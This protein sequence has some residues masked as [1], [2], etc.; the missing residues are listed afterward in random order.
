VKEILIFLLRQIVNL[1]SWL[2]FFNPDTAGQAIFFLVVC[3][4]VL[5]IGSEKKAVRNS[6]DKYFEGFAEKRFELLLLWQP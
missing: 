3:T 6:W 4:V 5:R 1:F 2:E